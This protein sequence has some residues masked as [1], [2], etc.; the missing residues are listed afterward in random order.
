[1]RHNYPSNI[2]TI[3]IYSLFF[4]SSPQNMTLKA[5]IGNFTQSYDLTKDKE[6]MRQAPAVPS[7]TSPN[8]NIEEISTNWVDK[9]SS[10]V[11]RSTVHTKVHEARTMEDQMC[12]NDVRSFAIVM[13]EMLTW[14]KQSGI[15]RGMCQEGY[16]SERMIEDPQ[17]VDQREVQVMEEEQSPFVRSLETSRM[18][19]SR[20]QQM[21]Q[22]ELQQQ[23]HIN[24]VC[25]PLP[26]EE[27][28]Y[29]E[30]NTFP[31][32]K[33]LQRN[34]TEVSGNMQ[35]QAHTKSAFLKILHQKQDSLC[36]TD[37]GVSS[38]PSSTANSV[39]SS[40]SADSHKSPR[41]PKIKGHPSNHPS[42]DVEFDATT[43]LWVESHVDELSGYRP[44]IME[45]GLR[46]TPI[47]KTLPENEPCDMSHVN[48]CYEIS[49][50]SMEDQED[51]NARDEGMEPKSSSSLSQF[52][53]RKRAPRPHSLS[54]TS[55]TLPHK[56]SGQDMD[57][58]NARAN[59]NATLQRRPQTC[60]IPSE[61]RL[62]S[63][64]LPRLHQ[65]SV[66]PMP[67]SA[68][69]V[70]S[71]P[72]YL[73]GLITSIPPNHRS[74][75]PDPLPLLPEEQ[76]FATIRRTRSRKRSVSINAPPPQMNI[77]SNPKHLASSPAG[78]CHPYTIAPH[79]KTPQH[80]PHWDCS[81]PSGVGEQHLGYCQELQS[82][83]PHQLC[84]DGRLVE[85]EVEC[86]RVMR[87]WMGLLQN[88]DGYLPKQ[89]STLI[90][91]RLP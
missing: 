52:Y 69:P 20:S 2:L 70:T 16:G 43:E 58:Y 82:L 21:L 72:T 32:R 4:F 7:P 47:P 18:P 44:C 46:R 51:Q 30:C 9:L 41:L 86:G 56:T 12:T 89:V 88:M 23:Q 65:R 55:S 45:H 48:A 78:V 25:E 62:D 76:Q 5:V 33:P 6:I 50:N 59:V 8:A 85:Q 49:D 75:T 87:Q 3:S 19:V 68:V 90:W 54:F 22:G 11:A 74:P 10:S 13:L 53:V 63:Q 60:Y 37:S 24:V 29:Y 83:F 81:C 28:D 66:T 80:R 35:K 91:T 79:E 38:Q 1:M 34:Q 15:A 61:T 67:G 42:S 31:R 17:M 14:L 71:F 73:P 40:S 27:M 36:S 57:L 64:T 39:H 84:P 77:T 26:E